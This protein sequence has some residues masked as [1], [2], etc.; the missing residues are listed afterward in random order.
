MFAMNFDENIFWKKNWHFEKNLNFSKVIGPS[1]NPSGARGCPVQHDYP[2]CAGD[3]MMDTIICFERLVGK[4]ERSA[5]S[6][7]SVI[8]QSKK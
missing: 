3:E 8:F 4:I 6:I 1:S 7:K 5:K 2:K